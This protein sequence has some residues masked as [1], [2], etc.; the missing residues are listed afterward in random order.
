MALTK[1]MT[2]TDEHGRILFTEEQEP[3]SYDEARQILFPQ[4][5]E[6]IDQDKKILAIKHFRTLTETSLRQAKCAIDLVFLALGTT[7][8]H[9]ADLQR[10]CQD[11]QDALEDMRRR[12][13]LMVQEY[14]HALREKD[15]II[16]KQKET[17]ERMDQEIQHLCPGITPE[18]DHA[19]DD[20]PF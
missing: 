9:I 3:L 15:E 13:D 14:I 6:A 11:K 19:D 17:I 2:I 16:A 1:S 18:Q 12:M 7:Q 10:H 8:E 4:I 20:L 5:L